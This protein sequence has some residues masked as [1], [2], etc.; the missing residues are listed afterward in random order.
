MQACD[1]ARPWPSTWGDV[2][3]KVLVV[4]K[5]VSLGDV[6]ETK[7]RQTRTVR[8]L[9]PLATDLA[10]WP[11]AQGRPDDR[12]LV[13]PMRDGRLWTDTAYRNWRRRVFEP[14]ACA[15]RIK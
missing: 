12:E 4:D 15:V 7:T 8:L 11:M 6:K 3:D 1:R 9:R 10:K 5:S 13:F 2:R 14:A